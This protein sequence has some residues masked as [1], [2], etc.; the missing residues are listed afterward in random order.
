MLARMGV[1]VL[2]GKLAFV[3]M[4]FAAIGAWQPH[5]YRR[6]RTSQEYDAV[7]GFTKNGVRRPMIGVATT[8]HAF[9]FL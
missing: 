6:N 2:G 5:R 4:K 1:V 8:G 3:N 7:G 9:Q